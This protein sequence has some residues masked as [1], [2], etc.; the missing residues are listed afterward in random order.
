MGAENWIVTKPSGEEWGI[1]KRLLINP[2]TKQITFAD[3]ILGETGRLVQVPWENFHLQKRRI[4]LSV[5][6]GKLNGS[7]RDARRPGHAESVAMEVWP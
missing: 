3:V 1:I 6:E 5:P 7:A 4:T 2:T